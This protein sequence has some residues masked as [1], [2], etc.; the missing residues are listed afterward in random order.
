MF[1]WEGG[2]VGKQKKKKNKRKE[3]KRQEKRER[4]R[5]SLYSDKAD[6]RASVFLYPQSLCLSP[7]QINKNKT[8][9][10]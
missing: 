1:M 5:V 2:A 10:H 7:H 3:R 4:T 6:H 8:N 9:K